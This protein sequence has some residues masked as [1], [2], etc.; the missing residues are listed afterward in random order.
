MKNVHYS[1]LYRL[2]EEGKNS[3]ARTNMQEKIL[4]GMIDLG[5]FHIDQYE[6]SQLGEENIYLSM[7]YQYAVHG[8]TYQDAQRICHLMGKR[9]CRYEEWLQACSGGHQWIYSYSDYYQAHACNVNGENLEAGGLR[10]Q[11]KSESQVYDLIGNL[12]EWVGGMA[13]NG[14]GLAMGGSYLSG[15]NTIC[16]TSVHLSAAK[17]TSTL[18]VRCC[19]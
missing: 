17:Q 4:K 10:K 12:S 7:P 8:V 18:G 14:S 6:V 2:Q 1:A 3:A 9:L 5:N 13:K 11:C 16:Y 19:L 15:A